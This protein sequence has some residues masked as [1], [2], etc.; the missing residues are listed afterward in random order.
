MYLVT[1]SHISSYSISSQNLTTYAASQAADGHRRAPQGNVNDKMLGSECS[2]SLT[3]I[4]DLASTLR[5]SEKYHAA[6]GIRLETG[7][8]ESQ[9]AVLDLH[10][11]FQV[12]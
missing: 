10:D 7:F 5:K 3:Y 1:M 6:I 4:D 8:K 11:I 9:Q 12:S 2:N